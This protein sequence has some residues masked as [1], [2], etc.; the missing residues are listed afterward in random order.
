VSASVADAVRQAMA[1][2][3]E[4]RPSSA[5][6]FA[7]LLAV[8]RTGRTPLVEPVDTAEPTA[9][10]EPVV[11]AVAAPIVAPNPPPV[12]LVAQPVAEAPPVPPPAPSVEAEPP[13]EPPA[14][15][16]MP[17]PAAPAA[18]GTPSVT[19]PIVL[20]VVSVVVSFIGASQRVVDNQ[21]WLDL[22]Y[23]RSMQTWL[24]MLVLL[25][26]VL[27]FRSPGTA[28]EW[29]VGAGTAY[30]GLSFVPGVMYVIYLTVEQDYTPGFASL[31]LRTAGAVVAVVAVVLAWR[32]ADHEG[33]PF[34]RL[35]QALVVVA[36]VVI[37]LS[38]QSATNDW[39]SDKASYRPPT[40]IATAVLLAVLLYRVL[41]LTAPRNAAPAL[42]AAGLI[43]A[44]VWTLEIR[45]AVNDDIG[46][47]T[48]D[49]T[50]AA[51]YAALVLIGVWQ[52]MTPRE[53]ST[54]G[55]IVPSGGQ[56]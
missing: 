40:L 39:Y 8:P 25:A 14:A 38:T 49:A 5:A 9:A 4:D 54:K 43:G 15:P 3:P 53:R 50:M 2:A 32:V 21:S 48:A 24:P 52:W 47:W 35:R 12:E 19:R 42:V 34:P 44:G 20:A 7:D 23:V 29:V 45:V 16:T 1:K 22:D 17:E 33:P 28:A 51:G 11:E 26:A 30:V 10:S 18:T 37:F 27:F 6:E 55:L 41:R 36:A 46:S 13:V 31:V 56:E